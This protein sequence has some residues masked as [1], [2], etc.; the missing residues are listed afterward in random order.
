MSNKSWERNCETVKVSAAFFLTFLP[1][2]MLVSNFIIVSALNK[3]L[4]NACF[5]SPKT[6]CY[7]M[8]DVDALSYSQFQ[9]LG[10]VLVVECL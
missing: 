2:F 9:K 6:L 1:F 5:S 8:Y 4:R 3:H 10:R 7:G